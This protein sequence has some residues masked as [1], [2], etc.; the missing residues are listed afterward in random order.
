MQRVTHYLTEFH[1][2][3]QDM[4]GGLTTAWVESSLKISADEE[5]LFW[6]R[7]WRGELPVSKRAV[8]LTKKITFVDTSAAGWT[9]NGKTGSGELES[10][11]ARGHQHQLQHG[12]FVGHVGRGDREYIFVTS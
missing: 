7:F 5:L 1:F 3:N 4:S 9:F 2:G 8:E 10:A 12:W 6:E 11:G